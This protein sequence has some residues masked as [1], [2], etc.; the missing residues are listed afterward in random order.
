MTTWTLEKIKNCEEIKFG[1]YFNTDTDIAGEVPNSII[2]SKDSIG[3]FEWV[4]PIHGK[5]DY[6]CELIV[7]N[8]SRFHFYRPDGSEILPPEDE[9]KEDAPYD[10]ETSMN[11]FDRIK[12]LERMVERL[13]ERVAKLI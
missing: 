2:I 12:R 5:D 7:K 6:E 3:S 13:N 10:Q 11:V 1:T 4:C 9:V 8:C